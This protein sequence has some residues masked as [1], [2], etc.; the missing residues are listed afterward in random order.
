MCRWL[1]Y[2]GG[3]IHLEDLLFSPQQNLIDQRH[4]LD[5]GW[6][7]AA[8]YRIAGADFEGAQKAFIN[9]EVLDDLW[10]EPSTEPGKDEQI[11]GVH[12]PQKIQGPPIREGANPAHVGFEREPTSA[13]DRNGT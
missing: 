11:D 7:T 3:P 2:S 13:N 8:E 4:G 10:P 1:A 6:R 12:V 5:F 9:A